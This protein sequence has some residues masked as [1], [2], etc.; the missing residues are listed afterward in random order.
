MNALSKPGGRLGEMM[1]M[2]QGGAFSQFRRE[3]DEALARAWK[4]FDR[5]E[6]LE[7]PDVPAWPAIDVSED[8]K[9]VT[10][11]VDLPGMEAKD[12]S[13]E[14]EGDVLT[15]KGSRKEEKEEKNGGQY[16]RER[17]SGSFER[18]L[19][20]PPYVDAQKIEAACDKGVLTV[21]AP[22]VVEKAP[23]TMKVPVKAS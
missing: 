6:W 9:A 21:K 4:A 13:V 8:D 19:K 15:I 10:M 17:F 20:L 18:A 16:R 7:V 12:V 1:G 5:D 22:K 2:P 23:Q 14:V 3:M 11:K